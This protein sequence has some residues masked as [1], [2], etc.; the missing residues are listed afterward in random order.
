MTNT[1]RTVGLQAEMKTKDLP[2]V[3]QH[4]TSRYVFW[5]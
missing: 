5:H 2:C 1:Y 4:Q 3:H